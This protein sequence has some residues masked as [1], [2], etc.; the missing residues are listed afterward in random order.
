MRTW[1]GIV[2]KLLEPLMSKVEDCRIVVGPALG[3]DN[4]EA[5]LAQITPENIHNVYYSPEM[6]M[7]SISTD[8]VLM[9]PRLSTS[10]AMLTMC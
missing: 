10:L 1:I 4:L 2:M 9:L 7:F 5:L 6:V 8:P 3:E